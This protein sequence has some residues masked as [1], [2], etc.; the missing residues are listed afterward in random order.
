[1]ASLGF[2]F[3]EV[4]SITARATAGNA[5][6][7]LFRVRDDRALVNWMG[8]NN[9]GAGVIAARLAAL[10]RDTSI[11]VFANVAR[12]PGGP[13]DEADGVA[14]YVATVDRVRSV[15]DAVVL[16]VSCPNTGDGRTFEEP[17]ALDTLLEGVRRVLPPG[18]PPLLVKLSAD[19]NPAETREVIAVARAHDVDGFVAINTTVDRSGLSAARHFDRG[20][21]SGEPLRRRAIET[22][23]VIAKATGGE[24][25]IVGVGG[26]SRPEHVAD[27]RHAG[28]WL[29]EVYTGF[30]YRGPRI[31]RELTRG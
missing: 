4:G 12:T 26:V 18:R 3:V 28:A 5:R 6:P 8:L 17:S 11:P 7:R 15:A 20:G 30:V 16:N 1:M 29:V 2:G 24:V 31:V 10:E 21:V 27:L 23:E 22:V 19:V 14:D 25:P 13:P 9:E